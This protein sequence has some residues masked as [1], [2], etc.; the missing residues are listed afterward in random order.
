MFVDATFRY[1]KICVFS[2]L[3]NI[4]TNHGLMPSAHFDL[5]VHVGPY[6]YACMARVVPT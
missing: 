3:M 1:D 2:V 6:A 5:D 4:K